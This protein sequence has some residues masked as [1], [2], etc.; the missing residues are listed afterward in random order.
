[1]FFHRQANQTAETSESV[2]GFHGVQSG[3][4]IETVSYP[5]CRLLGEPQVSKYF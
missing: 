3:E 4:G 2:S 1:M 5:V